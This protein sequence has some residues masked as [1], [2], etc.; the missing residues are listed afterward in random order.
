MLETYRECLRDVLDVPGLKQ[1]LRGLHTREISLVEVETADRLAVRLLAAVRLRRHLHVRGRHAQRRAPRRRALARPRPAAR[2]ARP[3]GAARADRPGRAR[4]RRR[5]PAAP[6]A[7][8]PAPPAATACTTSCAASAISA[9]RR[10]RERVFEGID[11]ARAARGAPARAARH[12]RARRRPGALDRRRRGRALPRR[13]RRHAARRAAR[14][15]PRRRPRRA[16]R[17]RRPLRAHARAIHSPT[18]FMRAIASTRA[19]C[20]A[21]SSAPAGSSAGSF[22]RAGP[23]N[24]SPPTGSPDGTGSASP[25]DHREWCDVEV[26][27]RLR[28]ASLAALRKEIEPAEQRRLAAFLPAWQG[29]DRHSG[30]GAGVDRLREVLVPLQGL[31]LPVEIW[32]RD[33]LPR[34]TGAYSPSWLDSALRERRGRLGRRRGCSVAPGASRCTSARTPPPSARRRRSRRPSIERAR[35]RG[36]AGEPRARPGRWPIFDRWAGPRRPGRAARR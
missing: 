15:L 19:P 4:A 33:V 13:A 31:A 1:L 10:S 36:A 11:A 21:S 25:I 30:A 22:V 26:L 16:A 6:L 27:R 35:R 29:V 20:C 9:R 3:G 32:E 17:A 14:R 7:R 2:A 5:R 28:R 23:V 18:S 8:S 34:R 12:P 24:R